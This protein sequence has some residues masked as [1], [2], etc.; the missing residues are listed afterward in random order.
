MKN[1]PKFVQAFEKEARSL[2]QENAVQEPMFSRGTYQFEVREKKAAFFPFIQ[3]QDSG[4]IADSFCSCKVSERGQ[5]CPHLAA[6]YFS[7]FKEDEPLHVRFQ[8][9]LWSHLFRLAAERHGYEADCLTKKRE[10]VYVSSSK[11]KKLLFSIE[12]KTAG[13]K[14]RLQG[15]IGKRVQETEETSLKFSNL[16]SEEIAQYRKGEASHALRYELSVW[17][18]LAKWLMFLEEKGA[19]CSLSFNGEQGS[20]PNELTVQCPELKVW[21][22][23]PEVWWPELIPA[24]P[25]SSPLQVFDQEDESVEA[26]EYDPITCSLKIRHK[27]GVLIQG[28]EAKGIS[29]GDW[30]FIPGKGFYRQQLDSL[31]QQ[32]VVPKEKIAEILSRSPKTLQRYLTIH[33]DPVPAQY[34]LFFDSESNLH[35]ELYAVEPGDL[36]QAALFPPWAYVSGSFVLL[37]DLLFDEQEKIIAKAEVSEFVSRHRLWLHQFP[38]FQTHLGSLEAHLTYSLNAEGELAFEAELD[39]PEQFEETVDFDEW[40]YIKNSGFYMK[41][42]SRGRLPLHPGLML[43]KEEISSFLST[44]KEELEQV[45]RFFASESIVVRTGLVI[46]LNEEGLIIVSPKME[47]LPGIDPAQVQMFG[48]FAYVLGRGFSE[49]PIAARLP[50]RYRTVVTVTTS[51]ESTCSS[52]SARSSATCASEGKNGCSISSMNQNS[53]SSMSFRFGRR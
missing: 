40:I 4:E 32:E 34:R 5:G 7:I 41:K 13:A 18:D 37:Q 31:F 51:Q 33:S 35:V 9:S 19:S 30:L 25:K 11:T 24:L 39:F 42:E 26:V 8:H 47:Y 48:D 22:Y 36:T 53:D 28:G 10:G 49:V 14:K 27:Q 1:P 2:L 21:L 20:V 50:E 3:M 15:I 44:H 29:V 46:G 43:K 45:H 17:S 23:I 16:S 52:R 12:A 6:A 38:G